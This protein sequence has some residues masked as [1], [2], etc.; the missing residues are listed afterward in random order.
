M[1][2]TLADREFHAEAARLLRDPANRLAKDRRHFT[3]ALAKR[4]A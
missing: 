1:T 2:P 3:A 4:K